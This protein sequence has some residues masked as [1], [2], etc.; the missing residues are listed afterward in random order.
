MAVLMISSMTTLNVCTMFVDS[1]VVLT[2]REATHLATQPVWIVMA[3]H[4]TL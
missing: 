2:K 3:D 4:M 1:A